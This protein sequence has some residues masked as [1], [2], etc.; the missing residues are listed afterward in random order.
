MF[1]PAAAFRTRDT[2]ALH[3]EQICKTYA[4]DVRWQCRAI[5][6]YVCTVHEVWTAFLARGAG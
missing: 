2:V 6:S 5:Q 1:E 4:R 3:Y